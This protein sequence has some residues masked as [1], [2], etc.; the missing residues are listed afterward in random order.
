MKALQGFLIILAFAI[1]A[2][3]TTSQAMA[4]PLSLAD[5]L[6]L[7]DAA[8]KEAESKSFRVSFA[9]VDARGDLI[10]MARVSGAAA[11]TAD[12]AIGKA[13]ISAFF[14]QKSAALAAGATNPVLQALNDSTGGRFRF[15]QGG[16]PIVRNGYTLCAIAASGATSQ[17]DEDTVSTA[18]AAVAGRSN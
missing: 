15:L 10:A 9:I 11:G 8:Q 4:T 5:A 12:T 16:V 18:L 13:M 7:I 1:V 6:Q 17:Q 3:S 2:P 14:G